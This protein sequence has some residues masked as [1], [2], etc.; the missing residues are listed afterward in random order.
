M[1][2]KKLIVGILLA[3]V[4]V[5]GGVGAYI[6]LGGQEV[7][8]DTSVQTRQSLVDQLPK[9][10]TE[11]Q[12]DSMTGDEHDRYY[13]ANM[14]AH[15]QGAVDMA[16]LA[17]KSAKH[18]ELKSMASDIITA[19]TGEIN[20]MLSWQKKWGYPAS[21]GEDMVDHS[22]MGMMED[23]D[24][25]LN[26]LRSKTG[27]E[28]DKL[29]LKQMITHHESAVAMSRPGEKNAGHQEVKDLTKAVIYAQAEEI[30]KMRQWQRD[31]GYEG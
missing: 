18:E 28:F 3:V 4:I 22:A 1:S 6:T 20:N 10:Q 23:M 5:T 13:I 7:S 12:L 29:F 26:E 15:H 24:T 9:T 31:W 27:D 8:N 21:S 19:Q 25:M 16:K 30:A 17:Q 14:I 11:K 2:D